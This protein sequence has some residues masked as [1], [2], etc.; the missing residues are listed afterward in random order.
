MQTAPE[1]QPQPQP[2][3]WKSTVAGVLTLVIGA[4]DVLAFLGTLVAITLFNNS[5]RFMNYIE[6]Q[7]YPMTM[8]WFS[9]MLIVAAVVFAAAA[10]LAILGGISAL[11]RKRWGLAVAGAI[12][13]IIGPWWPVGIVGTV[14]TAL[15]RDE[16]K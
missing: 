3:P 8:D 15:A 11:E 5:S 12:V 7:I 10:V 13:S 1:R 2:Q 9:A 16:F 14:F 6:D 4:I